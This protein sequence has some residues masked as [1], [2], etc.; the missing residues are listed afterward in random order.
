MCSSDLDIVAATKEAF[1]EMEAEKKNASPTLSELLR[2]Y[3]NLRKA[4]RSE[5]SRYGPVSYTHL[6]SQPCEKKKHD[7]NG[8]GKKTASN[9]QGC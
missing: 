4:E 7:T 3:M 2:D 1:A 8:L 9:R 6:L 5:W